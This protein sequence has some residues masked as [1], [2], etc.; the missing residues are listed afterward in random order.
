VD[1]KA[2]VRAR[3]FDM[4]LGDWDRHQD[5]WRWSKFKDGDNYIYKPIPRDRDQVFSNFDGPI[6][7]FLTRTI[8][9]L[10]KMQTYDPKIRNIK[11]H[12]TNGMPVDIFLL[13]SLSL[14]DWIAE[15]EHIQKNL[16]DDVI[17]EA[18]KKFPTEVQTDRLNDIRATLIYRRN[19]A[20]AIARDY[21]K[22]LQK[23][24]I[25][26]AT[27]KKDVITI[28]RKANDETHIT[29]A[30]KGEV[31]F[32]ASYDKKYTN[33]IWIYA[34]DD[35]DEITVTGTSDTYIA[36]KIIGGQ[37]NDKYTIE[38]GTKVHIYE[39]KSKK[40]SLENTSKAKVTLRDDY[41]TNT[42]DFYKRK[43]IVNKFIPL[44]GSNPDDGFFVGF[45][46]SLTFKNFR[47]NPF[48]HR[49]QLKA[50]YY[51]TN[52]GYDLGY[53]GEFANI[54]NNLDIVFGA[55]YT[56]PNF[57]TNFFGFGNETENFDDNLDLVYNRVKL[58]HLS[59]EL[60]L[61]RYGRQG[62]EFSIK[63]LFE[64]IRVENSPGRFL[65]LFPPN[66]SFFNRNNFAGGELFYQFK[67]YNSIAFP[68][69]GINFNVTGGWKTNID[70][71]NRNFGYLI[72][73]F[74]FTTKLSPNDR[75]V[76]ANKTQAHVTLGDQSDLEFYHLAT[77]GGNNG[78]RGFRHQ[79]F[80]GKNSLYNSMDLRYN[81]RKLKSGFA[82][83]KIGFYGG[84]DIGRVWLE[85]E[86]S[87]QWHNSIG[88]GVW[89]NVAQSL[90]GQAG[91]FSS[92]DG[93]RIAFGLGFGI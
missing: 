18:F 36:L 84:F 64:S 9:A 89:L 53:E 81:F 65:A 78:L 19:N 17:D 87:K 60:G 24:V 91:A 92:S 59:G 86:D 52:N 13:K 63:G 46:E 11:W 62:S 10:R 58:A 31:Y 88:G 41:N 69:K 61:V 32:E 28:T 20:K 47:Q 71:T 30:N 77:I 3:I 15:V 72:P 1:E 44:I 74:S 26:T 49:H 23:C 6:I 12:N 73:S 14:D 90:V 45:N 48:S 5:Q 2:F 82:P 42:F 67:N 33:E 7:G 68:T 16:T 4:I 27:D 70:N 25:L 85:G 54:M 79:R 55:R 56:S 51:I 57:A 8:P 38:N 34:L 80:T 66:S 22:I 37:N 93:V 40:N 29:F 43:D 39:Y 35:E 21:Y 50:S 76:L 75:F 83:M